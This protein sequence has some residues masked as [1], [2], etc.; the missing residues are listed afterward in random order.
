MRCITPMLA[1]LVLVLERAI[2]S[3]E[4]ITKAIDK[5]SHQGTL[6]G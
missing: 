1:R 4:K 5:L 3:D 6:Q 2:Q